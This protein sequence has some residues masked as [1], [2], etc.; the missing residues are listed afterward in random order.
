MLL[1]ILMLKESIF[2]FK[3]TKHITSSCIAVMT[4]DSQ[5]IHVYPDECLSLSLILIHSLIYEYACLINSLR[6][7]R[8]RYEKHK[9]FLFSEP[10]RWI[11]QEKEKEGR[12]S[13]FLFSSFKFTT[14]PLLTIYK[15]HHKVASYFEETDKPVLLLRMQPVICK[16]K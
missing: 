6:K 3:R 15:P 1:L 4:H 9:R 14:L 13:C 12:R 8:H 7:R 10:N 16:Q 5:I 2:A 11:M